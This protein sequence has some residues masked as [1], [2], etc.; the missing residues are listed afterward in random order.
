M[1]AA[2]LGLG[3]R[4]APPP[5]QPVWLLDLDVRPSAASP[6]L[7][8]EA[9]AD[10]EVA[11]RS[12]RC[13]VV[14]V[15]RFW[16]EW[17]AAAERDELPDWI[18]AKNAWPFVEQNAESRP[19]NEAGLVEV[20]RPGHGGWFY[21]RSAS[22][23]HDLLRRDSLAWPETGGAASAPQAGP[24]V[25]MARRVVGATLARDEAALS[26]LPAAAALPTA[27]RWTGP[28]VRL[29]AEGEGPAPVGSTRPVSVATGDALAFVVLDARAQ[30][31]GWLGVQRVAVLLHR[32]AATAPWRFL[33]ATVDPVTVELAFAAAERLPPEL[34]RKAAGVEPTAANARTPELL[35]PADGA[36]LQRPPPFES[37]TWRPALQGDVVAEFFEVLQGGQSRLFLHSGPPS[38][39]RRKQSAGDLWGR[40]GTWRV[41][42]VS[43]DG[44]IRSSEA[45]DY[46]S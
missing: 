25:E 44:A 37:F 34:W 4:S 6:S 26:T 15:E 16:S 33:C 31:E 39:G 46:E 8:P 19:P 10:L 29:V 22:P 18:V 12:G 24:A 43:A 5:P 41:W 20:R 40:G 36:R 21:L 17:E 11:V 3:C 23:R 27:G 28:P 7:P 2:A 42:T 45:R 9:P 1:L 35:S 14:N 32:E 38:E 30:G 13:R